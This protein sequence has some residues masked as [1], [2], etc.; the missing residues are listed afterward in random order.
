MCSISVGVTG[1]G[2]DWYTLH[3]C[4]IQPHFYWLLNAIS[5]SLF[6]ASRG[7]FHI[8][9]G[10]TVLSEQIVYWNVVEEGHGSEGTEEHTEV[11]D[12]E[13]LALL[14]GMEKYQ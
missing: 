6:V 11:Y 8:F 9:T 3:T 7:L 2:N 1:A 4:H 10:S 13:M 14:R 12:T 5:E